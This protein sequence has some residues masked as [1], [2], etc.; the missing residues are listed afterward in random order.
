MKRRSHVIIGIVLILVISGFITYAAGLGPFT[1]KNT[2]DPTES[3]RSFIGDP[4]AIVVFDKTNTNILGESYETYL[5]GRDHFTIDPATGFVSG[6][7]FLSVP[8]TGKNNLSLEHAEKYARECAVR[9]YHNFNSR[10]MQLME[11]KLLDHGDSGVEY[12]F[13]WNEQDKGISIGNLVH[14]SVNTDGRVISYHA[15]DKPSAKVEPARVGKEQAIETATRYVIDT[16]KITNITGNKTSAQLTVMSDDNNR[17]VWNVDLELLFVKN[18]RGN[19]EDHR[20]GRVSVDAMTGE[21]VKYYP[22]Q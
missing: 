21:V 14:V 13:T 16:T 15:R 10:N 22:C 11:S 3:I 6:A 18:T 7:L 9:N 20:G 19:W 1:A 2:A 17:V 5:V 12:S 8:M 4:D